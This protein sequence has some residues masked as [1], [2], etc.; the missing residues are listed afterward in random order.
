MYYLIVE[1]NV[2]DGFFTN[3][4]FVGVFIVTVFL[5]ILIVQFGGVAFRTVPLNGAEWFITV[6]IGF[7][8]LPLGIQFVFVLYARR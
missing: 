2:F 4:I 8:S 7:G 1:L 5:Q 6:L 3:S